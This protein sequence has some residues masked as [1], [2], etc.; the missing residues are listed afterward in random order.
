MP[1]CKESAPRRRIAVD[2]GQHV[3]DVSHE[4][5]DVGI[6]ENPANH[7]APVLE[8]AQ[9]GAILSG[10][11]RARGNPS[12]GQSER[13]GHNL[14]PLFLGML[15]QLLMLEPGPLPGVFLG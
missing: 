14:P 13:R 4:S 12:S 2:V 5:L 10:A 11:R 8:R 1:G 9:G 7:R 3:G 15:Q 6:V